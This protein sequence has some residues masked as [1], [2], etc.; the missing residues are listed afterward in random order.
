M[1]IF[2]R[3]G[4]FSQ[5]D[6]HNDSPGSG[7]IKQNNLN[8]DRNPSNYYPQNDYYHHG[9]EKQ[10]DPFDE[11][12]FMSPFKMMREFERMFENDF[13][14]HQEPS[15]YRSHSRDEDEFI[16]GFFGHMGNP[17]N[18]AQNRGGFFST[19]FN[20]FEPNQPRYAQR[21]PPPSGYPN[22]SYPVNNN[23]NPPKQHNEPQA[24]AEPEV[25]KTDTAASRARAKIY[26][27]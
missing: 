13:D 25:Q 6:D 11:I 14:F 10:R 17:F 16:D 24:V 8:T 26:D 19:P 1:I 20:E 2:F 12:G 21:F 9:F 3:K 4:I 15:G 5:E 7:F 27:V 23:F 22:S 18:S